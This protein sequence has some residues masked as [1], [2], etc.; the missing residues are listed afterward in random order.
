MKSWIGSELRVRLCNV[1]LLSRHSSM[2]RVTL[3]E[4]RHSYVVG[5]QQNVV[6]CAKNVFGVSR[7]RTIL[8]ACYMRVAIS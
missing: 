2:I 6:E 8:K 1:Y 7:K 4:S 5:L 3:F